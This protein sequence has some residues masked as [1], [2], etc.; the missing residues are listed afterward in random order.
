MLILSL[1]ALVGARMAF[2]KAHNNIIQVNTLL[3][4]LKS[5][6]EPRMVEGQSAESEYAIEH[7]LVGRQAPRS[8]Q[9]RALDLYYESVRCHQD[10]NEQRAMALNQEAI[11]M[12]SS[13]HKH[14]YEILSG[15]AQS[16]NAKEAG[17]IF[18]WLGI[19]AEN[20]SDWQ[21]AAAWYEKAIQAFG[22]LGYR[23]RESRAHC[24]LGHV[25][26]RMNDPSGMEEFEKAIAINPKNGT[27]HL[28]IARIYYGISEAGDYRYERALDAFADAILTDPVTYGPMV[29]S[30]LREIGYT[31]KEDL[32][33][34][35]KKIEKK[36]H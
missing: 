12:D 18:Y 7:P 26:M 13:L 1:V 22:Q 16:C 33:K 19:H 32:E 14:A 4:G 8:A 17:S 2:K 5:H 31:W 3:S 21:H 30:S 34:I 9:K 29:V 10:G 23:N 36:Q 27:A 6:E 24:N 35:T 11:S 28:N 20:L 25:K 15:L